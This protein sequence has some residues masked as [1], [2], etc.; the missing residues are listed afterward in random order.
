MATVLRWKGLRIMIRTN[1]H[2]PEHVH[3]IGGGKEAVIVLN[4]PDGPP[5]LRE[6]YGFGAR[7]LMVIIDELGRQISGLCAEWERIHG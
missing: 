2:R 7:D 6:N 1:D 3:V 5:R 4:C